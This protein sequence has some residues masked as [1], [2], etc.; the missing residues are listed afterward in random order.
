MAA[1]LY[2]FEKFNFAPAR[3]IQLLFNS[4]KNSSLFQKYIG[5]YIGVALVGFLHDV[6]VN[7]GGGAD[8]CVAQALR[9]RH[10]VHTVEIQHTC[11]CMSESVGVDVGEVVPLAEPVKPCSNDVRVHGLPAI[12]SK[13]KALILIV[14]PQSKPFL[15]LPCPVLAKELHGF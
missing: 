13:H 8:L 6:G 5:Q 3:R 14:F 11:H 12:L 2:F 4:L 9:D 1:F 7:I 15:I 10:A